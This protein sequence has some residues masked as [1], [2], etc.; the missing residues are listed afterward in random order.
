MKNRINN[1]KFAKNDLKFD[2]KCKSLHY[3]MTKQKTSMHFYKYNPQNSSVVFFWKY[4]H[5][6]DLKSNL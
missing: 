5:I 4:F 6:V 3:L 2:F 1:R